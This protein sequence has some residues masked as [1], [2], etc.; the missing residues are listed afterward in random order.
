MLR[1]DLPELVR[2]A[3]AVW[4]PDVV[5]AWGEPYDSPLWEDRREGNAYVCREFV[6]AAPQDT[7]DG[8]AEL[9]V[10]QPVTVVVGD[11]VT[12]DPGG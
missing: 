7:L 2:L 6:C 1:T 10:G 5:L 9:L 8:F 11:A 12:T 4:R 3:H